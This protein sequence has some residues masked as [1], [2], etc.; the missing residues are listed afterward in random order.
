[1]PNGLAEGLTPQDFADLIAYLETLKDAS[2]NQ[3]QARR[4]SEPRAGLGRPPDRRRRGACLSSVAASREALARTRGRSTLVRNAPSPIDRSE[5]PMS[6]DEPP[7]RRARRERSTAL[8]GRP[9]GRERR[10]LQV[11]R[12]P[13]PRRPDRRRHRHGP[14]LQEHQDQHLLRPPQR[15][16]PVRPAAPLKDEGY[17]LTPLA[18][19]ILHPVDPAELPRLHRQALLEPPLYAELAERLA[20]KRVPEAAILGNVLYHNHQ[21]IAS[22]KQSAAE[23]FLDSARFAGAL[24]DDHIFRP[25]GARRAGR[26]RPARPRPSRRRPDRPA[27]RPRAPRPAPGRRRPDRPPALGRRRRQGRSASGPPSRS[28]PRAS[29]A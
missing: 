24:G 1:M 29:I 6:H 23:A 28:P 5:P 3:A 20:D 2:A 12:V 15:R 4:A 19:S 7:R 27:G 16:P 17:S 10:A 14:R 11:H 22:A 8:S 26:P 21:I 18:R 9:P 25:Q 13:R